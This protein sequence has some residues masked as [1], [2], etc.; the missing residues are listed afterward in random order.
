MGESKGE[1]LQNTGVAEVRSLMA[2]C[3][4][5]EGEDETL[6][7]LTREK[8]SQLPKDD[9]NKIGLEIL[10]RYG[11]EEEADFEVQGFMFALGTDLVDWRSQEGI[12]AGRILQKILHKDETEGDHQMDLERISMDKN[13]QKMLFRV[14]AAEGETRENFNE[15]MRKFTD[16]SQFPRRINILREMVADEGLGQE[17]KNY[18]EEVLRDWLG[19]EPGKPLHT[20]LESVYKAIDF[21]EY[22]VNLASAEERVAMVKKILEAQ[23]IGKEAKMVD[24]GSGTG[25]FVNRMVEEGYG[26]TYG[27]D[28]SEKNVALAQE[29]C[30]ETRFVRAGWEKLPFVKGQLDAVFCLGRTLPHCEDEGG[31]YRALKEMA[32]VVKRGGVIVI[33]MPNPEKGV[34]ARNQAYFKQLLA[35]VGYNE[36]ELKDFS[37]TVDAPDAAERGEGVN[38]YNRYTP[39]ESIIRETVASIGEEMW[40]V[41]KSEI[42]NGDS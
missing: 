4:K 31:F 41:E 9:K 5:D 34:Y 39:K 33:D 32:R 38:L 1:V 30:G 20:S 25:W 7:S 37:F 35:R 14:A 6:R 11:R 21:R 26:E 40:R 18:Y 2:K 22:K 27:V 10:D 17:E 12:E 28:A 24:I 23:G 29:S 3:I 42:P 8:A 15:A 13:A 16:V 19:I 36:K